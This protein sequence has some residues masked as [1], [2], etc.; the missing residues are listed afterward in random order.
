[1]AVRGCSTVSRSDAVNRR[2][3]RIETIALLRCPASHESS[4]LVTVAI[5]REGDRLI[6][7]TLGCSVCGAEYAL[8]DGVVFLT[9]DG[10]ADLPV[11]H[12][13]RVDPMRIAAL[14]GVGDLGARVMLCGTLGA[15]AETIETVTGALC[16]VINAPSDGDTCE[17]GDQLVIGISRTIPLPN[18]SLHGVAVDSAHVALLADAPRVVRQGGR[19]VAPT[20]AP[21]PAGC[22]ELARDALEWVA[23][24]EVSVSAPVGLQLGR[25]ASR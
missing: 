9:R 13:A 22:R 25:P 14:L 6:D 17:W 20:H 16:L 19:V 21:V 1:M 4:P 18:A 12:H 24:V 8:R 2:R 15:A 10:G 11:A 7:A 23:E 3:L 5:R